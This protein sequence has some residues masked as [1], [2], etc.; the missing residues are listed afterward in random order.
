MTPHQ[1]PR[2]IGGRIFTPGFLLLCSV[3]LAGGLLVVYR[4]FYGLGS[5]S[6]MNDGY[7]WGI[8]KPLNVV[9]FTGLAAGAYAMGLLTYVFN[10]WHYHHLIRSAIIAGAMGYTLAGTSVLIDLGRWWNLWVI[11][12]PPLYNLNS[13]LLEVAICVMAY[14]MVLWV[15]VTPFVLEQWTRA[16]AGRLKHFATR[17]LP[18]VQRALPFVISLAL[19]LPTMHQSSLGGLYMVTVTKLHGLWHS[20]WISGL[21]L[22]SCL[23]MGFGAVVVIENVTDLMW[24]RRMDQALLARMAPVPVMLVLS[25]VALR[26]ADLAWTGKVALLAAGDFYCVL[27]WIEIALFL[28]PALV[29]LV[30]RWRLNRGVLF[31]AGC[32][33]I[34]AGALYRFDT[35]LVAYLPGNGW[36]YFPS[37]GELLFSACLAATGI[38]VYVLMVKLF[39][40]LTGV[41]SRRK[42]APSNAR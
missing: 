36:R 27:F 9:T 8:W 5:V 26:L 29:L 25:F 4:L 41:V 30:E 40:V 12:W 24:R 13:V 3:I 32:L 34:L 16:E 14:T 37:L 19:L 15:E 39:P 17:A 33:L 20:S 1:H 31:A 28:V 38:A 42:P 18:W 21:F 35:Y 7:P 23:T 10:H 11:F 22:L 2:P 6:A